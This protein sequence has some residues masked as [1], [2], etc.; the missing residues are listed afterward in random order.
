MKICVEEKGVRTIHLML[1]FLFPHQPPF[2]KGRDGLLTP[3]Q[4]AAVTRTPSAGEGQVGVSLHSTCVNWFSP[5]H[6]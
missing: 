3:S 2:L 1:A 5:S 4:R 6:R